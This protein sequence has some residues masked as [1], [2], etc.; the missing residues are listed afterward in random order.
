MQG[1]GRPAIHGFLL[2]LLQLGAL[3]MIGIT[4]AS[5]QGVSR[6]IGIAFGVAAWL[7]LMSEFAAVVSILVWRERRRTPRPANEEP[8]FLI[9][10]RSAWAVWAAFIAA[11]VAAAALL[12]QIGVT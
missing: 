8:M 9:E 12:M 1:G 3:V 6:S 5:E 4:A 11:L 2:A 10:G 7:A